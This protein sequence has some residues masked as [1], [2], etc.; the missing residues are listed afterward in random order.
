MACG[1]GGSEDG[2]QRKTPLTASSWVI[3]K[4][5]KAE[6]T[7]LIVMSRVQHISFRSTLRGKPVGCC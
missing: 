3:T 7:L 2:V 5:L 1:N 6:D 4:D